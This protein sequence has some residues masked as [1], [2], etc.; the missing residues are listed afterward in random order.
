MPYGRRYRKRYRR[1]GYKRKFFGTTRRIAKKAL[2]KAMYLQRNTHTEWKWHDY[3][4]AV[5][6]LSTAGIVDH[7]TNIPQG[8]LSYNRDGRSIKLKSILINGHFYLDPSAISANIRMLL[9]KNKIDSTPTLGFILST[10]GPPSQA[11]RALDETKEYDVILDKK[12]TLDIGRG[13]VAKF[14]IFLKLNQVCTYLINSTTI[15]PGQLYLICTCDAV[16]TQPTF[17]FT[18]RVRFVDG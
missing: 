2:S 16:A 1:R 10:T 18:S 9:V 13:S 8:D 6:S 4:R 12:Y 7:L 5:T 15:E 3:N 11:A 14:N 17:Q